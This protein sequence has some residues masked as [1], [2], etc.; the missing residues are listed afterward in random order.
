MVMAGEAIIHR[1]YAAPGI[2]SN[3]FQ[4]EKTAMEKAISWLEENEDWRNAILICGCKSL[5]DAVGNLHA[6]DVGI[7]LVQAAAARLNA[8]RCLKVL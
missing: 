1:W 8:E 3:S 5:V 4:A 2:H 6:P 7:R